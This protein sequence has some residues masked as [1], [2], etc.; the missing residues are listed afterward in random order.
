MEWVK[1]VAQSVKQAEEAQRSQLA[2]Q[3][4][5]R[6][7]LQVEVP[8]LWKR[9]VDEVEA[10]VMAFNLE[11][12]GGRLD[13]QK[14]TPESFS[15]AKKSYPKV[16]VAVSLV[17]NRLIEVSCTNL[18]AY[19]GTPEEKAEAFRVEVDDVGSVHFVPSDDRWGILGW[20]AVSKRIA[21]LALK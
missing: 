17:A 16:E 7:I 18:R 3:L 13:F 19:D 12:D 10:A 2:W 6:E 1:Q 9:I 14:P 4:Q 21:S 11:F 15:I 8:R 20:N 5:K